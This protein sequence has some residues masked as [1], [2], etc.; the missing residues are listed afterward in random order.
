MLIV[1]YN[2]NKLMY[3]YSNEILTPCNK[4][5][6]NINKMSFTKSKKNMEEKKG[7]QSFVLWAGYQYEREQMLKSTFHEILLTAFAK[8]HPSEN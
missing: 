2:N 6:R 8:Y 1:N 7:Y 3:H 5:Q 4:I